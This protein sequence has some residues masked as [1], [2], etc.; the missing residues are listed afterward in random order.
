[1]LEVKTKEKL[2]NFSLELSLLAVSPFSSLFFVNF[3]KKF[4]YHIFHRR[5]V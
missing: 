3:S 2:N 4:K 5:R 1:M